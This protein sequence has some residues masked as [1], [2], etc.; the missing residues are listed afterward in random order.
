MRR[1]APAAS[2]TASV[3]SVAMRPLPAKSVGEVLAHAHRERDRARDQHG[4][5]Q[6]RQ[7][8]RPRT[9]ARAPRRGSTPRA[10]SAGR[11]RA[12]DRRATG[13]DRAGRR[14]RCAQTTAAS[15][16]SKSR[17]TSSTCAPKRNATCGTSSGSV[18]EPQRPAAPRAAAPRPSF[19]RQPS[20]SA[21]AMAV[22]R[23]PMTS[24]CHDGPARSIRRRIQ[25]E[26]EQPCGN[27]SGKA[28]LR[29]ERPD[30]H[31]RRWRG[32]RAGAGAR[33]PSPRRRPSPGQG[34]A[35]CRLQSSA[36]RCAT[37][38]RSIAEPRPEDERP[39]APGAAWRRRR[40][41]SRKRCRRR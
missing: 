8:D 34:R 30:R 37:I 36:G 23:T 14:S 25:F 21:N 9:L 7:L 40:R 31:A 11:T 10:H 35:A 16:P 22:A 29:S 12:T 19:S 5:Q 2:V 18:E 4:P 28:P 1:S 6:D 33:I 27:K 26:S 17:R 24:V 3:V 39:R 41:E 13:T 20:T 38:A 15:V 32:T